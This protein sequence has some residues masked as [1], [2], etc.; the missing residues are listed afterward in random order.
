MASNRNNVKVRLS[1]GVRADHRRR[2]PFYPATAS[3]AAFIN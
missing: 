1:P 3:S 2:S